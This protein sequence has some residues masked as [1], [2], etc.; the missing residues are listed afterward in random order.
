M[1]VLIVSALAI[2]ASSLVAPAVVSIDQKAFGA[3][4]GG[5]TKRNNQAAEYPLSGTSYR[6]YKP[7][8]TTTPDGGLFV[9]LRIDNVR[10]WLASDD[11]AMLE[12][13]VSANGSIE[14]AQ[15]TIAIQGRSVTS[16]LIRCGNVA[17]QQLV[18][19]DRAVKIGSDLVADLTAKMLQEQLV[20]PG[21]VSYP[22]V[23]RH[24]YNRL[25][26]AIRTEAMPIA[27]PVPSDETPP[28]A[29]P[30]TECKPAVPP[31]TPDAT[32]DATP[33]DPPPTA[34]KL[35]IKA[36]SV[37]TPAKTEPPAKK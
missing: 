31:P 28:P 32:P 10:G 36:P 18:G 9:S 6:T 2:L 7:E 23:L 24:N 5:W 27:K 4:L 3:S 14:S 17:G 22:A 37:V 16:D 15:S 34:V 8:V 11:H 13:T 12:I 1:N 21:R 25:F 19:M 30:P 35:E 20:E 33:V 29:T 26:Q